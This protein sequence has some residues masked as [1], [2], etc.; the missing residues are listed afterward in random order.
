MR[1]CSSGK[2][3]V[4]IGQKTGGLSRRGTMFGPRS[5]CAE[6]HLTM[7]RSARPMHCV[8]S[9]W[10][11]SSSI[12]RPQNHC[13]LESA[14][15]CH[16]S[17]CHQHTG[18]RSASSPYFAKPSGASLQVHSVFYYDIWEQVFMLTMLCQTSRNRSA[19]A[20]CVL[21]RYLGPGSHA[22][23]NLPNLQEQVCKCTV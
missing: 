2:C 8:G 9:V 5:A 3:L 20:Q 6:C 14:Q 16:H 21:Q 19:S 22:H 23:H 15:L 18:S 1:K 7:P 13:Q 10:L 12:C 4:C 11:T 17:V